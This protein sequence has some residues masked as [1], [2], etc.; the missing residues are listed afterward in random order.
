MRKTNHYDDLIITI[1]D[2]LDQEEC[3]ELIKRSEQLGYSEASVFS[4][5]EDKEIVVKVACDI[6]N[7]LM[8]RM[9]EI[10]PE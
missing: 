3:A 4:S 9:F 8:T 2:V 7:L 5:T 1:E 10:T 6:T